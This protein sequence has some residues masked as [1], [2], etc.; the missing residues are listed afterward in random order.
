MRWADGGGTVNSVRVRLEYFDVAA[1]GVR[2]CFAQT[3]A[4]LVHL[5]YRSDVMMAES[6]WLGALTAL[7]TLE[8]VAYEYVSLR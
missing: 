7:R 2:T 3:F 4:H 6:E 8:I 1:P 5:E